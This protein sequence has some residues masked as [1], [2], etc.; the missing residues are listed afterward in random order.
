MVG[1]KTYKTHGDHSV[2]KL[3][4][5]SLGLKLLL[6]GFLEE[7]LGVNFGRLLVL[8]PGNLI[9]LGSHSDKLAIA[10]ID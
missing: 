3:D 10:V 8:L 9:C 7:L 5:L 6:L 2:G 4:L 1:D